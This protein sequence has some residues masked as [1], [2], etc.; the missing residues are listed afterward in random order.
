VFVKICGLTTPAAVAAAVDA[1]ADAIGFVFAE[2]PRQVEP[3]QA[4]A[5]CRDVPDGIVRVAVMHH[6][7]AA[8]W[9]AVRDHF[10][11]DWLQTDAADLAA[12]DLGDHCVP[13]P[14]YRDTDAARPARSPTPVLFEGRRSGSGAPADW[15]TAAAIA[16][17]T[18][19]ILAGGLSPDNVAAAIAAVA[20]WGVDVSSGVESRPGVKDPHKIVDFVAR[21]RAVE[22]DG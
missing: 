5:L 21:A 2:S 20:P 3:A 16:R 13:L 9:N 7:S 6:P 22:S 10:C 1:G 14:V 15:D 19:L 17:R 8:A 11:P 12:L 4:V 18:D